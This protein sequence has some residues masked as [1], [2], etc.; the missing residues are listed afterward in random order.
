MLFTPRQQLLDTY[1]ASNTGRDLAADV[2]RLGDATL[3]EPG[4]QLP[5]LVGIQALSPPPLASGRYLFSRAQLLTANHLLPLPH[6]AQLR[7]N[8]ACLR[9]EQMQTGGTRTRYSVPDGPAVVIDERK[10]NIL[11]VQ[12]LTTDLGYERNATDFYLKNTVSLAGS[13]DAQAGTAQLADT[14]QPVRQYT[15]LPAFVLSNRLELV[16]PLG[17]HY[18]MQLRSVATLATSSQQ[19][20][21]SPGPLVASLAGGQPYEQARQQAQARTLYTANTL[22][23]RTSASGRWHWAYT[24]GCTQELSRLRSVL[25]RQPGPGPAADTLRNHLAA[26]QARYYAEVRAD[27][28]TPRWHLE[29]ALPLSFRTFGAAD[30]PLAAQQQRQLLAP[31]FQASARYELS[32]LWHATA[33]AALTNAFGSAQLLQ[34]GYLLRDYRTLARNAAPLVLTRTWDVQAGLFYENPLTTWFSQLT[35]GYS[36]FERNQLPRTLV[37]PDG[38]LITVA[39]DYAN[40]SQLQLVT[41]SASNFI[42]AWK[43]TVEAQLSG[44]L[45]RQPLVLNNEFITATSQ[46]ATARCKATANT[47]AWGGLSYSA[48]LTAL[49]NRV[50]TGGFDA[51]TW[52]HQ[53]HAS[54][55]WF[56]AERH[57]LLLDAEYYRSQA[58]GPAV[59]NAFFDAAYRYTL[60]VAR[61]TDIELKVSNLFDTSIYQSSSVSSFVLVQNDY[62]LRP[63]QCLLTLCTTW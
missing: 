38:T 12:R 45:N 1:Q 13:W 52:L 18:L 21:V 5:T 8:V 4:Q 48:S 44:N 19:L 43:T 62:R 3:T 61:K 49:R 7:L 59:H 50:G 60:P 28:K 54:A 15:S 2:Q 14:A 35:Y 17:P 29:L 6:Q 25:T 51:G 16:R 26:R 47:F 10:R 46:S 30:A 9:D 55:S 22:T 39:I 63:R 41:A 27:Y 24:A 56:V 11:T 37:R 53:Q 32:A 42:D 57:L 34:Y 40:H 31:E 23:V 20:T 36:R 33:S 58:L